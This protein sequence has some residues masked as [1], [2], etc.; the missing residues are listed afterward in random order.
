MPIIADFDDILNFLSTYI[1]D[2]KKTEFKL[3]EL[4]FNPNFDVEETESN[5]NTAENA[6]Y[7]QLVSKLFLLHDMVGMSNKLISK[8]LI[9][10][11]NTEECSVFLQY[12]HETEFKL[13]TN[14]IGNLSDTKYVIALSNLSYE[15][16]DNLIL[17]DTITKALWYKYESPM[18]IITKN[19]YQ[20]QTDRT[21]SN[22]LNGEITKTFETQ[23]LQLLSAVTNITK[24]LVFPHT[25]TFWVF[26]INSLMFGVLI[27]RFESQKNCLINVWPIV[28]AASFFNARKSIQNLKI[29]E[30]NKS[31]FYSIAMSV[32][33]NSKLN[34]CFCDVSSTNYVFED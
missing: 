10:K 24:N 30:E 33:P 8:C 18:I 3:H 34:V 31:I 11:I 21:K 29:L 4:S 1:S 16:L 20:V 9:K 5:N 22:S 7:F 23:L 32:K 6:I 26:K 27:P 13:I 2:S 25:Y 12:F 14:V 28:P 17:S 15:I 19:V